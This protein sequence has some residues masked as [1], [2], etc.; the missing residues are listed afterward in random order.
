[1]T[2]CVQLTACIQLAACIC[3]FLGHPFA[4]ANGIAVIYRL[5]LP[6]SPAVCICHC[7]LPFAFALSSTVC[8]RDVT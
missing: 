3:S 5:R 7:H 6:L 1:M 8:V 2:A 4:C